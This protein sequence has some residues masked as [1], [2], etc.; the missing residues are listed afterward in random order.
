MKLS[1]IKKDMYLQ[2]RMLNN[3]GLL[4]YKQNVATPRPLHFQTDP[5]TAWSPV[6][7]PFISTDNLKC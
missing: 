2:R 6:G 3:T 5:C 7:D 1:K 4:C